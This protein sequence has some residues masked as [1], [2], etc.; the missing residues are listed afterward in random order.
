M[1]V[2]KPLLPWKGTTLIRH[3]VTILR[4]GG[5]GEIVV[6]IGHRSEDVKSELFDQEVI[7]VQ[8]SD[9]QSGRVSSVKA[10][11]QAANPESNAFVLLG[12][13]QPRTQGVISKLINSHDVSESV[14]TSPRFEFR[15]GHPVIF[16]SSIRAEMLCIS[17]ETEG[18]RS[19]FDKYR[20][21]M[22]EVGFED[23]IISL[24]L[25][26]YEEYEKARMIYGN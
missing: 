23:P 1:G 13:D 10:G 26:T 15:G 17:E 20:N 11:I 25:N 16:S 22:N 24:D 2:L 19:V 5:C 3:Q 6:V 14:I 7:F 8:N 21:E 12:V 4:H 18:L 9:Y